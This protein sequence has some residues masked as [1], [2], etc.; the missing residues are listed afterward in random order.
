MP[1]NESFNTDVANFLWKGPDSTCVRFC[2]PTGTLA[3]T[4]VLR[5]QERKPIFTKFVMVKFKDL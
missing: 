5:E 4:E 1:W 2:G 3:H